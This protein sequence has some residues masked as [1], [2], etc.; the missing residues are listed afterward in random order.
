MRNSSC[1]VLD[2]GCGDG[3]LLQKFATLTPH[4]TGI[5]SDES[6]LETARAR[7]QT[8]PNARILFGDVLT[9]PE[10]DGQQFG[11]VTCVA[12]LHH[13]PL[14]AAL[15]LLGDL[16][17]P[18]GDLRIVGL[19]ANKTIT[20]WVVSGALLAPIRLASALHRESGYPGMAT[21]HPLESLAEIR[22]TA[23]RILPGSRVRRRFY[24]RYTLCWH[25][26]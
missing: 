5:D 16:V 22:R 8:T 9:S 20:D 6:A 21:A 7:L 17:A 2:V 10:L 12:A 15:E 13:L 3:L 19:S 4:V 26:P 23:A 11:L 25:K 24:Y 1:R 14:A 18:G